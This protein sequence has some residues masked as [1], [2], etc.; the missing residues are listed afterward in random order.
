MKDIVNIAKLNYLLIKPYQKS[1]L[2]TLLIPLFFTA[3]S[4]SLISGISFAM[5]M[6]AM[7]SVYTFQVEEKNQM[8]QIVFV[9]TLRK[10]KAC[11][12]QIFLCV[13]DRTGCLD[14][15]NHQQFHPVE[16]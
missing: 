7:T 8:S 11:N 10:V 16:N 9:D 5:F 12:R 2:K 3:I 6:M 4:R 14:F 13:A 15:L 1:L